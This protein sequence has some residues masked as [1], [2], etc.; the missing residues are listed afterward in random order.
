MEDLTCL[1]ANV[2]TLNTDKPHNVLDLC[3]IIGHF[4]VGFVVPGSMSILWVGIWLQKNLFL[5][6]ELVYG[7]L[8][9]S[10]WER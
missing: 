4:G 7:L 3:Y 1:L 8:C 2:R 9:I 5:A 6:E 10:V